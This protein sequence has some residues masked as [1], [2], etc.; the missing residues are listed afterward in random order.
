MPEISSKDNPNIRLFQKLNSGKKHRKQLGLFT[1][2]GMRLLRDAISSNAD[3]RCI[4]ITK[5]WLEKQGGPSDF[6]P[7]RLTE[8]TFVISDVLGGK[9]S[10]TD[11]SQGIFAIC[12]IPCKE[13]VLSAVKP[14][15]KYII[16][17]NISD[18]GNMGTIIRTADAL[19]INAVIT[20]G[21]CDIYSPKAIRSTMGSIFRVPVADSGIETALEAMKGN[22]IITYAAVIDGSALSLSE[23]SFSPGAAVLI[24]NEGN[25]LPDELAV[26]CDRRLTIKMS[27]N[28]NSFNA[29]MAAGI[30]MWEMTKNK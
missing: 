2:E 30:I 20:A 17:H 16:L 10:D 3:V 22:G 25:G 12:G 11:E 8:K 14:N 26:K 15:G 1:L 28:V 18:P 5:S 19:G 24:G 23:C 29:A 9:I 4:F 7:G 6:I 27:G 13:P 21:C